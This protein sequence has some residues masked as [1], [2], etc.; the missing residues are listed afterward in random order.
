MFI[1]VVCDE[2]L[3]YEFWGRGLDQGQVK[4]HKFGQRHGLWDLMLG[5]Y[6]H[7]F[8]KDWKE[9][10]TEVVQEC[11]MHVVV[12]LCDH[13]TLTL[14]LSWDSQ[15]GFPGLHLPVWALTKSTLAPSQYH[16]GLWLGTFRDRIWWWHSFTHSSI[17]FAKTAQIYKYIY[18]YLADILI[19]GQE[20]SEHFENYRK[21]TKIKDSNRFNVSIQ[22]LPEDWR[23]LYVCMP[24][25]VI[26][27]IFCAVFDREARNY[28]VTKISIFQKFLDRFLLISSQCS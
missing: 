14:A 2:W 26:L 4:Y 18:H 16:K 9:S 28:D 1:Q 11:Q 21:T 6:R 24:F 3:K 25:S 10:F 5:I 20:L 17:Y 8:N 13:S 27:Y 7:Q 23:L 22:A 19:S 12:S 15:I